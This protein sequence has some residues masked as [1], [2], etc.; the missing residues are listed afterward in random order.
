M[1]S[2]IQNT[3]ST[4]TAR[5]NERCI[6][7]ADNITIIPMYHTRDSLSYH[8]SRCNYCREKWAEYWISYRYIFYPLISRRQQEL[9]A[10]SDGINHGQ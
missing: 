8:I 5:I 3:R 9:A 6:C 7:K 4:S 1:S 2:L 10:A